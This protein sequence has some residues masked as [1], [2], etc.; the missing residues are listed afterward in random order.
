MSVRLLLFVCFSIPTMVIHLTVNSSFVEFFHCKTGFSKSLSVLYI[1]LITHVHARAHTHN[2]HTHTHTRAHTNTHTHT[3]THTNTHTYTQTHTH[4][5]THTH[6]RARARARARTHARTHAHTCARARASIFPPTMCTFF[7]A[8]LAATPN[9]S[10]KQQQ[11]NKT[12]QNKTKQ[13][14][15]KASLMTGPISPQT[16]YRHSYHQTFQLA[17]PH[18]CQHKMS[19]NTRRYTQTTRRNARR[20]SLFGPGR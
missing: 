18:T 12:K 16:Q 7:V 17:E 9:T 3:Y 19:C 13:T 10:G 8:T 4:T 6:T 1:S 20:G 15:K 11:Q 14:N 5:H 2:T